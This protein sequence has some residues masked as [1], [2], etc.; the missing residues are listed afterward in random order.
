MRVDEPRRCT[1]GEVQLVRSRREQ[2]QVAS[3][4]LRPWNASEEH[5]KMLTQLTNMIAVQTVIASDGIRWNAE[6]RNRYADAVKSCHAPSLCAERSADERLRARREID[7]HRIMLRDS[8]SEDHCQAD[9]V[10]R[11]N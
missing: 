6:R 1:N 2:H 3:T 8:G 7:G 9:A 4:Q 10:R 5:V 11:G